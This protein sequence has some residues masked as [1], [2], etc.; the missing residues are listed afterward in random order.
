MR[1]ER[2]TPLSSAERW[3]RSLE[4]IAPGRPRSGRYIVVPGTTGDLRRE[5]FRRAQQRRK[6][7]F[8]LLLW[9]AVISGVVAAVA[10]GSA[11]TV[12]AALDASLLGYVALLLERKNRRR[13]GRSTVTRLPARRPRTAHAAAGGRRA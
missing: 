3:R 1:A 6:Q 4:L 8:V 10:G 12:H 9:S 13:R 5:A 2:T 11:W 7:L